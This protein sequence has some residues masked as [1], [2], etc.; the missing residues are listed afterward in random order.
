MI[1]KEVSI[2]EESRETITDTFN[3]IQ[4]HKSAMNHHAEELRNHQKQVWGTI[5]YL[6]PEINTK[7]YTYSYNQENCS[8]KCVGLQPDYQN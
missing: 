8:V 3:T 7:K 4:A 2:P 6:F 1:G 5:K